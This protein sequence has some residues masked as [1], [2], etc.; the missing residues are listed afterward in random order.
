MLK[1]LQSIFTEYPKK[2]I[3]QV[4]TVYFTAFSPQTGADSTFYGRLLRSSPPSENG[5][6]STFS[7]FLLKHERNKKALSNFVL[8]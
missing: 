4:D 7:R 8:I 6:T 1:L 3:V 2:Y 5:I